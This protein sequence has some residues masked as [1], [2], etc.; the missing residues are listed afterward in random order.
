M[1]R[2]KLIIK[3]ILPFLVPVCILIA[4]GGFLFFY[5]HYQQQLAKEAEPKL[6]TYEGKDYN[7]KLNYQDT[8]TQVK[9]SDSEKQ[10]DHTMLRLVRIDP[11]E[12]ITIWQETGLGALDLL[13]KK[14]LLEY[15]KGSVDKRYSTD[16][17]DFKK[18]KIEDTKVAGLDSFVVWFTFQDKAKSYREKIKLYV[19]VKDKVAYYLQCMSPE[20]QWSHAEQ[21]CDIVKDSFEL[22]K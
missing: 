5:N 18:E 7:L 10:N 8:F 3:Q 20:S 11:P 4:A 17:N 12:L 19:F 1:V 9:I 6:I 21:S 16:Y 14:P 2:F 15:L 13:I 22:S